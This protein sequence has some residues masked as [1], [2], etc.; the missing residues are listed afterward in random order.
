MSPIHARRAA[1]AFAL[2]AALHTFAHAGTS[3]T[4]FAPSVV[5]QSGATLVL[6]G[7]GTR[8]KAIFKVYD[9]AL[10]TPRKADSV[11]AVLAMPGPKRLQFVALRE[12]STSDLGRLFVQGIGDNSP[13]E[14]A[15]RHLLAMSRL[16]EIFSTRARLLVGEQ[17]AMDFIPG[18]GT[19]FT[20]DGK[21]QGEPIGDAEFFNMILRIWFGPAPADRLLK[22]A[23]LG[24]E[25]PPVAMQR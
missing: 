4:P 10:Y 23:L 7:A 20:L 22:D 1:A 25:H 13:R 14:Q 17:F 24:I 12:L 6:N 8:Y 11:E 18:K 3:V 19:V 21:V 15:Q 2:A 5:S 16:V 9:L